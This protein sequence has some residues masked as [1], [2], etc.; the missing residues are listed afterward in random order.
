M[1]ERRFRNL[2]FRSFDDDLSA[3]E[4][5]KFEKELAA[6]ESLQQEYEALQDMRVILARQKYAF[7]VGFKNR[8]LA[9]IADE[10]KPL[11]QK[12]EFNSSLYS[13]FKR[14]AITGV[15]AI[16]IILLSLYLSGET[17]S[18][19]TVTGKSIHSDEDLVSILLYDDMK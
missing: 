7:R 14:V 6:S 9:R 17:I 1:T 3:S 12:P 13:M 16:V 15:A 2:L 11:F 5:K 10:K 19:D 4:K 8:V 18:L